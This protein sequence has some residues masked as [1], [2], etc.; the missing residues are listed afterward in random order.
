M[1]K[2]KISEF[3]DAIFVFISSF[4]LSFIFCYYFFKDNAVP[5]IISVPVGIIFI[6]LFLLYAKKK[7]GKMQVKR[8]DEER[9]IKCLNAL[10]LKSKSECDDLI[11]NVLQKLEKSPIKVENGVVFGDE[12]YYADFCYDSVTPSKI[13]KAYKQTPKSKN[14]VFLSITFSNESVTFIRDFGKRIRLIPLT[15]FFPVLKQT[16]SIPDGGFIPKKQKLGI[17]QLIIATFD[18]K[19][20][21][22][23]TI[24]GIVLIIM[25]KFVFFPL[26]YI[27]SGSIFLIYALAVKFFAPTPTEKFFI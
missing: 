15:E 10:C 27:I 23:F 13:I 17:K 1:F 5:I 20:A 24:Y 16:E 4:L 14:L 19:R 26:W 6:C 8:E 12:F 7:K 21:K 3:S 9:F 2:F 11:F 22:T 25:S 18:R